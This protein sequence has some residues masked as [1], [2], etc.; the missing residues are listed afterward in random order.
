MDNKYYV[1]DSKGYLVT[2]EAVPKI[3]RDAINN[4]DFSENG[5]KNII[6]QLI[7]NNYP[8]NIT[9]PVIYYIEDGKK[10]RNVI[11]IRHPSAFLISTEIKE[12]FESNGIT[13]WKPYDIILYRKDGSIM[14]GYYGFTVTGTNSIDP[15]N[16]DYI[17]DFFHFYPKYG[18]V[19][20]TQR[21]VDLLKKHKIKDFEM[22]PV[23]EHSFLFLFEEIVFP[24]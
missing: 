21:V 4:Q 12:L 5:G 10:V 17:P 22:K 7:C 16:P 20:C 9:F 1:F 19:V 8:S 23:N 13:G 24:K 3:F 18:G 6:Q 11:E 14:E 15:N 2:L